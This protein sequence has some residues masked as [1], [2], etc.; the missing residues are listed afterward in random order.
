MDTLKKWRSSTEIKISA[1]TIPTNAAATSSIESITRSM[2]LRFTFCCVGMNR[3]FSNEEW[4][5][6]Q[7]GPAD[8]LVGRARGGSGEC[9][10]EARFVFGQG[11]LQTV[12]YGLG[13]VACLAHG[14]GPLRLGRGDRL[15]P[16]SYLSR[17]QLVHLVARGGELGVAG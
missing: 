10:S 13:V 15:V 16:G 2:K 11:L 9:G 12:E 3:L 4:L 17:R 7:A 1:A 5:Q 6:T 14:V 8:A